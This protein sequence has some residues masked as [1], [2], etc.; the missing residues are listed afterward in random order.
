[1]RAGLVG[2]PTLV[3]MYMPWVQDE[4]P[5]WR[6]G[7]RLATEGNARAPDLVV[8]LLATRGLRDAAVVVRPGELTARLSVKASTKEESIAMA[9]RLLAVAVARVEGL[10][11]SDLLAA[12]AEQALAV[13]A[14]GRLVEGRAERP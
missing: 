12:D 6:I 5:V 7:L 8:A 4:R 1:M 3:D 14:G 2:R 10:L 13:R 11:I 9:L